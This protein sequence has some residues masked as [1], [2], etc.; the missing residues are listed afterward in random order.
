MATV[1]FGSARYSVPAGLVGQSVQVVADESRILILS[2]ETTVAVH[3]LVAPGEVSITDDHY[4]GPRKVPA[5]AVRPRS[6]TERAFL[7]L[8]P[9]AEDF[10]R[11]AAAAGVNKLPSELAAIVELIGPYGSSQVLAAL[12]RGLTFRR[13]TA[14]DI[15]SILD[16]GTGVAEVTNEGPSVDHG[17]PAVA[18]RD[19]SA[20]AL[21]RWS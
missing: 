4:G 5:R 3:P 9:V 10:L 18:T 14:A 11:A 19:L 20:Y 21:Q 2:G 6:A 1:R 13:F 7:Q 16:A 8:G 12:G 17:L 15:R